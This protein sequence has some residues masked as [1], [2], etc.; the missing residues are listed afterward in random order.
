MEYYEDALT[1]ARGLDIYEVLPVESFEGG[2]GRV[3]RQSIESSDFYRQFLSGLDLD[4][5]AFTDLPFTTTNDIRSMAPAHMRT[6]FRNEVVRYAEST[7]STTSQPTTGCATRHDW[8]ENTFTLIQSLGQVLT[9]DD[10]VMIAVPYSLTYVGADMDRACEMIGCRV[11]AGGVN[12]NV[13]SWERMVHLIMRQQVSTIITS[14]SRLLRLAELARELG[15]KLAV[16]SCLKTAILVGE[17]VHQEKLR[18]LSELWGCKILTTY[19]MTE[20]TSVA[21]PCREGRMHL[22]ENRFYSEILQADGCINNSDGARGELVLTSLTVQGH[23]LVRY[24]TGDLVTTDRSLCA[25]GLPFFSI[26][27]HGRV[28]DELSIDGKYLRLEDIENSILQLSPSYC[29]PFIRFGGWNNTLHI[30][31][32]PTTHK[33]TVSCRERLTEHFRVSHNVEVIVT[34]VKREHIIKLMD[35]YLK[36]GKVT[37]IT[38]EEMSTCE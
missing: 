9:P 23:P 31:L 18:I 32:S 3:V 24:R 5:I 4:S 30:H 8:L 1:I 7:G 13:C 2:V 17:P 37:L 25:C 14:P 33:T 10:C 26:T 6:T 21:A 29:S 20:A 28:S 12:P 22:C 35:R 16:N 27:H 36:P 11:I 38:Q 34:A 15:Y 19:G